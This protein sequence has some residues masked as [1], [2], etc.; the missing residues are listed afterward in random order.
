MKKLGEALATVLAQAEVK[1]RFAAAGSDVR[2]QSSTNFAQ[3]VA[4]ENDKWANVIRKGNI[5]L[6]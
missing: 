2:E 6:D 4:A 5:R 3:Y 1:A